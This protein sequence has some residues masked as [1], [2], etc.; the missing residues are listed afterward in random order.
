MK[1]TDLDQAGTWL[2]RHGFTDASPT[3]L[4]AGRLA[5]RRRAQRGAQVMVAAP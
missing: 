3:P 5:V 1:T 2:R 4:L